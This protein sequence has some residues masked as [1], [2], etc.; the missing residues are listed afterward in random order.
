MSALEY[1]S[2]VEL[3]IDWHAIAYEYITNEYN[4]RSRETLQQLYSIVC[5]GHLNPSVVDCPID[6][7]YVID[8]S[9]SAA[10]VYI[11]DTSPFEQAMA[12]IVTWLHCD[13]CPNCLE[14]LNLMNA[15]SACGVYALCHIVEI[16][17]Y[18][19]LSND[20]L[21]H[22]VVEKENQ[23]MVGLVRGQV[24]AIGK[25]EHVILAKYGCHAILLVTV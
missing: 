6:L 5:R 8:Q 2:G 17:S 21:F 22:K 20:P 18:L 24:L 16:P 7:F 19:I 12:D 11:R 10:S 14:L 9:V 4:S 15:P 1:I 23:P 3:P 25:Q 13:V